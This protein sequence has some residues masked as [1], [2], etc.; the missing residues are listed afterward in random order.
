MNAT[1]SQ[2]EQDHIAVAKDDLERRITTL[3]EKVTTLDIGR[4]AAALIN[5]FP[6]LGGIACD[7]ELDDDGL[8]LYV[9]LTYDLKGNDATA[10]IDPMDVASMVGA[11]SYTED[12]A[13]RLVGHTNLRAAV[14]AAQALIA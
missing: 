10:D 3:Q 2:A 12:V 11:L 14:K 9:N 7:T 13:N 6:G 5:E 1:I 8:F 4:I